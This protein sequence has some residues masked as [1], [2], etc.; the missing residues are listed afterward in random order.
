MMNR[1]QGLQMLYLLVTSPRLLVS[2]IRCF[3]L[4]HHSKPALPI[5]VIPSVNPFKRNNSAPSTV[6]DQNMVLLLE[7]ISSQFFSY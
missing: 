4:S 1:I 3:S 7:N 6:G 2:A 5:S